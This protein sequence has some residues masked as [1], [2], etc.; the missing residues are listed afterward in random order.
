MDLFLGPQTQRLSEVARDV[1]TAMNRRPAREGGGGGGEQGWWE[2]V[3]WMV[4]G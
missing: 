1:T 3:G 2:D 4:G